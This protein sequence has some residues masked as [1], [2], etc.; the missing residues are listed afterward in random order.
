MVAC[1]FR[2]DTRRNS[3]RKV[4]SIW[5]VATGQMS[6][7]YPPATSRATARLPP[8]PEGDLLT[9]VTAGFMELLLAG[10]REKRLR[11][12]QL[13]NA[14]RAAE[15]IPRLNLNSEDKVRSW[16]LWEDF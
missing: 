2:S 1:L 16:A 3:I 5:A 15:L 8:P 13:S 6:E 10:R 12:W 7:F 14:S 4:R 9:L 11:V